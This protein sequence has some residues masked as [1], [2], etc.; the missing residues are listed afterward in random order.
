MEFQKADYLYTPLFCEE[1][2]WQ[3][4]HSL[5]SGNIAINKMWCLFITNPCHQVPLLNQQAAPLNQPIIWDYHVVLLAEINHPPV[6][7]DFDSR[8]GFVTPL[9]KYL[10]NT[11]I[12]SDKTSVE[13]PEEFIPYIRK[14]PAQSYLNNFYSDRSHMLKQISRSEYPP[15]RII[16]A[17]KTHCT[18]LADYLNIKQPLSDNSSVIKVDL[19][20]TLK[21]GLISF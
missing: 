20:N 15:W 1:N 13:L 7:F 2:I 11:F 10:T 5:A 6:I 9:D 19:Y 16:N 4:I 3:L 8:L 21:Q 14:I 17:D 18:P 12:F